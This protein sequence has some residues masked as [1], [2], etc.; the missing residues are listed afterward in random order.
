MFSSNTFEFNNNEMS[1]IGVTGA[2]G[3]IGKQ[4]CSDLLKNG[5]NFRG[6]IRNKNSYLDSNYYECNIS[7]N[8]N[9][10]LLLSG[11]DCIVH[12]AALVHK[13]KESPEDVND[14]WRINVL[15]T[16]HLANEAARLGVKR[17]IFISTVKVHGDHSYE[18]YPIVEDSEIKPRNIYSLSKAMAEYYL[19]KLSKSSKMEIV[20]I[21]PTLVYGKGVGGNF[22]ALITL[23]KLR[24]PL[25]FGSVAGN[26]R[27]LLYLENLTDLIINSITN[28]KAA[29]NIFIASDGRSIST[30]GLIIEISRALNLKP[31]LIRFP[32]TILLALVRVLK[33]HTLSER[34]LGSLEVSNSKARNV[35]GWNP[36]FSIR[37]GLLKTLEK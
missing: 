33:L 34:I 3:F 17:F 13:F 19:L 9:W 11:I 16:I 6:F 24:I 25:P 15:G 7:P 20:I 21:R 32:I 18:G 36:R 8:T 31:L 23:I 12:C 1:I 10:D 35:L 14:Y 28:S 2:N 30:M 26:K 37:D 27:S 5:F 29:N 4:L 22:N